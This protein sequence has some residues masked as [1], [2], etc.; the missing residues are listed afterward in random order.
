MRVVGNNHLELFTRDNFRFYHRG[1]FN[2]GSDNFF[3]LL[4]LIN[5]FFNNRLWLGF[6][7]RLGFRLWC[8]FRLFSR[9]SNRD[10]LF[11]RFFERIREFFNFFNF[12][13]RFFFPRIRIPFIDSRKSLNFFDLRL[14]SFRKFLSL[15]GIFTDELLFSEREIHLRVE[16]IDQLLGVGVIEAG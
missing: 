13:L 4:C 11:N 9:N 12:L 7:D 16:K 10:R 14:N 2:F 3:A 15:Y 6:F 1:R 8:R 5:W